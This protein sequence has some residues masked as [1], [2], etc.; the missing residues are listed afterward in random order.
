MY[1][2]AREGSGSERDE[3]P[4]MIEAEQ[5]DDVFVDATDPT[6]ENTMNVCD[7]IN[8]GAAFAGA[9]EVSLREAMRSPSSEEWRSAILSEIESLV[10]SETW[11]I[12]KAPPGQRSV[13]C[14]HK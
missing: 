2:L 9:A 8:S 12:V 7:N 3:P 4:V 14:I 10:R 11:K 13:G 1:H 5:D 6:K